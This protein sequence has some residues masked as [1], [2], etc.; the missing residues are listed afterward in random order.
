MTLKHKTAPKVYAT[1]SSLLA[2]LLVLMYSYAALS[3][4]AFYEENKKAMLNQVFSAPVAIH[5]VWLVPIIELGL[6]VML[7][8]NQSRLIG[9]LASIILM[10]AFTIYIAFSMSGAFG[11]IPCSCGGILAHMGY[12]THLIFNLFFLALSLAGLATEKR[13]LQHRWPNLNKK[14]GRTGI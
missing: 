12:G 10:T 13:F 7:L 4:L 14:G 9:F 3:K 11:R 5:L 1:V 2:S 8:I 6:V